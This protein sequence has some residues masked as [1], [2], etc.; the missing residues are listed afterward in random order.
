MRWPTEP[1]SDDVI[2]RV[3]SAIAAKTT[4]ETA[5]GMIAAYHDA[6]VS[7]AGRLLADYAA[8]HRVS[9]A[10]TAFALVRRIMDPSRILDANATA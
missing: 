1:R 5:K 4:L 3:Q 7:Q 2:T 8:G 6:S 9:L 10:D